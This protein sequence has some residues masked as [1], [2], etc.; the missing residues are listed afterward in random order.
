MFCSE[1]RSVSFEN[2]KECL[3]YTI[4]YKISSSWNKFGQYLCQG[5]DFLAKS[6]EINAVKFDLHIIKQE[7]MLKF[8]SFTI[9]IY[10]LKLE[11]LDL[12]LS[13]L[14]E[15]KQNP[16]GFV[17]LDQTWFNVLPSLFKARLLSVSKQIPSGT[18]FKTYQEL[19]L[20]WKNMH[21]YILP[22]NNEGILYYQVHFKTFPDQV[23]LYP[24]VCLHS[25]APKII[26]QKSHGPTSN[27]FIEDLKNNVQSICG[28]TLSFVIEEKKDFKFSPSQNFF[29]AK[30]VKTEKANLFATPLSSLF[31]KSDV[32][33]SVPF[34]SVYKKSNSNESTTIPLSSVFKNLIPDSSEVEEQKSILKLK[35]QTLNFPKKVSIAENPSTSNLVEKSNDSSQDTTTNVMN[36][37]SPQ[38]S[39]K[40]MTE[41]TQS[42]PIIR[43]LTIDQKGEVDSEEKNETYNSILNN[44]NFKNVNEKKPPKEKELFNA[45]LE[46]KSDNDVFKFIAP[47]PAKKSRISKQKHSTTPITESISKYFKVQ[48]PIQQRQA[49]TQGNLQL[50]KLKK[51]EKNR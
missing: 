23:F 18:P 16:E 43:K 10:P 6:E 19:R 2:Y 17:E 50:W 34:S 27:K 1:A 30:Q 7:M 21:G 48:K 38:L 51:E 5:N 39:K 25:Q 32:S 42:Q 3:M 24:D 11:D 13:F 4:K 14:E 26:H 49:Q 9:Q 35:Q 12:N 28:K 45:L 33:R 22:E 44:T 37:L 20:H 40:I 15:F 46:E 47:P 31:K 41:Y 29:S 8:Q 36:I